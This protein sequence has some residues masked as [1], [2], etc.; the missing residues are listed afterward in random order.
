MRPTGR[1]IF[2]MAWMAGGCAGSLSVDDDDGSP[3]EDDDVSADD[4]AGD[5]DDGD[6]DASDDDAADDDVGDDD[7]GDDDDSI[8]ADLQCGPTPDLSHPDVPFVVYTGYADVEVNVAWNDHWRWNGC[9]AA[10]IVQVPGELWCGVKWGM[11]ASSYSENQGSSTYELNA[12][13][14]LEADP[15]GL[16]DDAS[17]QYRVQD[18]GGQWDLFSVEMYS[19]MIGWWMMDPDAPGIVNWTQPGQAGE[20]WIEFEGDPFPY[21]S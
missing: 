6:D 21:T 2:V 9:R 12:S 8:P 14:D 3:G 16:T 5:D 7:A 18:V 19:G 4:D 1:L 11:Q 15:C 10:Y 20:G 17:E 13:L